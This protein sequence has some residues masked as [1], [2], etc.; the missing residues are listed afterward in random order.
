MMPQHAHTAVKD[1]QLPN[2][3]R[4]SKSHGKMARQGLQR[5]PNYV[6]SNA[7]IS[8][9]NL[10]APTCVQYQHVEVFKVMV[11]GAHVQN[12]ACSR[13]VCIYLGCGSTAYCSIVLRCNERH[14]YTMPVQ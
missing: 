7:F 3:R 6:H 9:P 14:K 2:G 4:R 12:V 11:K 13:Q 10:T 5:L 1:T 8:I